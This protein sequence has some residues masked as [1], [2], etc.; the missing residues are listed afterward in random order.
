MRCEKKQSCKI[1]RRSCNVYYLKFSGGEEDETI[2]GNRRMRGKLKRK[3]ERR[4]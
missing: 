3:D 2:G 1:K 4:E